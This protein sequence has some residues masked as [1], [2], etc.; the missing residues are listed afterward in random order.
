MEY[1]QAAS[2]SGKGI[3]HTAIVLRPNRPNAHE[4]LG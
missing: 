2:R 3:K 4:I 1:T